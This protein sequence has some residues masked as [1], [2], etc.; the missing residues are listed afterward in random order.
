MVQD[1]GTPQNLRG[2]QGSPIIGA[3]GFC[4]CTPIQDPASFG[5]A[6]VFF[7]RFRPVTSLTCEPFRPIVAPR[8]TFTTMR[9]PW[10]RKDYLAGGFVRRHAIQRILSSPPVASA[11]SIAKKIQAIEC[12][13]FPPRPRTNSCNRMRRRLFS[14]APAH[15][16]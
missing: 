5:N 12:D 9:R 4:K 1:S 14:C 11:S 2:K 7:V 3:V 10:V 6:R 16:D 13:S 15:H 8:S